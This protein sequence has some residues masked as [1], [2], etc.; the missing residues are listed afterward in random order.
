M[1]M[2]EARIRGRDEETLLGKVT[3]KGDMVHFN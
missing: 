1:K 2:K 3:E